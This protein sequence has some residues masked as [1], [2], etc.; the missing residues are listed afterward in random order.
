MPLVLSISSR[1]PRCSRTERN[2]R[3][4][5]PRRL[6]WAAPEAAAQPIHA[7][8]AGVIGA[9][10]EPAEL[11]QVIAAQRP[12]R[13]RADEVTLCDLTGTGAQDTAI[14]NFVYARATERGLGTSFEA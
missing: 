1:K 11:G 2:S 13:T 8:A 9:D 4:E 10:A 14:A 3:G 5:A 6:P 7:I 12:G